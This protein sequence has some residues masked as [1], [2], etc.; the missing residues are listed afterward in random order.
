VALIGGRRLH[1]PPM[2]GHGMVLG[3]NITP[4]EAIA[5]GMNI[6]MALEES[7]GRD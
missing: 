1:T 6:G 2:A 3:W 5:R 4:F 7:L